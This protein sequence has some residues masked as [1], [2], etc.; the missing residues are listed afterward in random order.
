MHLSKG[1]GLD[2]V[3]W[4]LWMTEVCVSAETAYLSRL[5][6]LPGLLDCSGLP[7][8]C[9]LDLQALH[10]QVAPAGQLVP[11]PQAA[12]SLVQAAQGCLQAEHM[13]SVTAM[14]TTHRR[15]ASAAAPGRT[16]CGMFESAWE[17]LRDPVLRAR[18][19]DIGVRVRQPRGCRVML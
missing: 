18:T 17:L 6:C 2:V 8:G 11:S 5:H 16:K 14:C 9:W 4:S 15:G 7:G 3:L 12:S 19:L 1:Q 13:L 10:R